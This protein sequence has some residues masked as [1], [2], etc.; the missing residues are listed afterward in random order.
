MFEDIL[1]IWMKYQVYLTAINFKEF[2]WIPVY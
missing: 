1:C 2:N